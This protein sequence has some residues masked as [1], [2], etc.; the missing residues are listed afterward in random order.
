M[1]SSQEE[2][3]RESRIRCCMQILEVLTGKYTKECDVRSIGIIP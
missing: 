2:D 3:L 1:I